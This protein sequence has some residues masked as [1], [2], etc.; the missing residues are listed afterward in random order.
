MKRQDKIFEVQNLKAKIKESKT[1]ALAD[2]RGLSVAQA[3]ELRHQIKE[4]GGELQVVKNRLLLRALKES[5]YQIPKAKLEGPTL[6]LF[7]IADEISP[8]KALV[9]YG[10]NTGLLPLKLGFM[11]GRILAAEELARFAALPGK[12]EL[13]AKLVSMLAGQP[14]RL[15]YALNYNLQKLALALNEIK[16]KK[17]SG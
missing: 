1:V 17:Q 7:A 6:A 10:K 8:L 14:T 12:A 13:Q 5:S 2:Y 9:T 3:T 16:T 15:A 4:A 11:A